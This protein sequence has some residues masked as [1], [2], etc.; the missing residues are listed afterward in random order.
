MQRPQRPLLLSIDRRATVV[1]LRERAAQATSNGLDGV[2]WRPAV[3]SALHGTAIA[4]LDGIPIRALAL[5]CE[6]TDVPSTAAYVSSQFQAAA[7]LGAKV[8][9]LSI[10]PLRRG[11]DGVGFTRYPN[12]LNF[13]YELLR[14][15]R[16]EAEAAG[17]TVA[18]EAAKDGSLLS[19]VEVGELIDAV[20]SPAVGVCLD[21][22]RIASIGSPLDWIRTLHRRILAVRFG[23]AASQ[24]S[25]MP[26]AGLTQALED[27]PLD[28]PLILS[29]MAARSE[30]AGKRCDG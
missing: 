21:V 8:L 13:A 11:A 6:M 24:T 7:S 14:R 9:N 2:E 18:L 19:P 15:L 12:A 16:I 30:F 22:E 1:E 28:C 29:Q 25:Q 5:G 23:G 27:I 26:I 10:P 20:N 3:G 4:Q 17:V